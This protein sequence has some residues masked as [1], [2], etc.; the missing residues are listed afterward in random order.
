MPRTE[1]TMRSRFVIAFE[2]THAAMASEKVLAPLGA[3]MMPVPRAISAGC[4]MALSFEARDS[5][6][7]IRLAS[8]PEDAHGMATLFMDVDGVYAQV[9]AI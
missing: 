2:S 5:Q 3:S 4:G 6:D 7:A 1:G 8:L 9:C